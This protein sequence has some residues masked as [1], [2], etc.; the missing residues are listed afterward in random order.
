MIVLL[1][2][3]CRAGKR[4]RW[5]GDDRLRPLDG[6]GRRQAQG[7]VGLLHEFMIQRVFSS[8]YLRC[9]QSVEPLAAACGLVLEEAAELA[10]GSLRGDVLGL[11]RPLDLGCVALCTHGDV[12]EELVGEML[13]KASTQ[14]LE[15]RGDQLSL[16]RYL[17]RPSDA[18]R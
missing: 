16:G 11:L 2:R 17:G 15:L 6:K 14:V 1:V 9:T 10:E 4:T 5:E 8:P 7:L 13:P 18:S 12:V 3:H